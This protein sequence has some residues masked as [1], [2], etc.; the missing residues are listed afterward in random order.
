MM[1]NLW[2]SRCLLFALWACAEFPTLIHGRVISKKMT[3]TWADGAP[4]GNARKMIKINDNFPGPSIFA[5][6]G[7][8]IEV[9]IRL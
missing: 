4:N 8:V 6:Q 5:D 9:T 3:L 7:D 2:T 1:V